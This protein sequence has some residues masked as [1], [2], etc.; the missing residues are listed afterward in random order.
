MTARVLLVDDEADLLESLRL[1]LLQEGPFEVH[2]ESD[3]RVAL[4]RVGE[5]P[6]DL[7]V[8]DL[9][10][11]G[12]HGLEVL[13]ELSRSQPLAECIVLTAVQDP[14]MAVQALKMGAF[15]YL[16]KPVDKKKLLGLV[17]RVLHLDS[18]GG[19]CDAREAFRKRLEHPE[20]FA[21]IVTVSPKMAQIFR[22]LER[23]APTEESVVISGPSGTGKELIAR[24]IH[25]L[26]PR[27]N[28]PFVGV[29][30]AAIPPSLFAS[31][32][33]GHAAGAFSGAQGRR[34]G[35]AEEAAEGTLFL[36][37]IGELDQGLQVQLL[38][39]LQEREYFVVGETTPTPLRARVV[40]ASNR[41]LEEETG[42]GRFR[43]DLFYRLNATS[44]HVPPLAKRPEDIPHLVNHFA[45]TLSARYGKPI[46]SVD[47]RLV[48]LLCQYPFPG[49]VRELQNVIREA[50]LAEDT[51]VLR[52]SSLPE[53]Y[54][55]KIGRDRSLTHGRGE[56]VTLAELER[57]HIQRVLQST[58][59]NV[60]QAAK[61]LGI[62]R[63]TLGRRLR[64][65][66]RA[67]S[68]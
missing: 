51:G 54:R 48:K 7:V 16:T 13:D 15:D 31:E 47:P 18:G 38:R 68:P 43:A 36:D 23:V 67:A 10:M 12:V 20:A 33:F 40:V 55:H 11:P 25:R 46:R 59:G 9:N 56:L 1:L 37:E 32:L 26:S 17:R 58:G 44:V 39:V 28:G 62:S 3:S 60:T 52:P 42:S 65:W 35:F 57:E 49:N 14:A 53:A 8:L 19:A 6:W 4:R 29:N 22:Y 61:V 66:R 41:D 63:A 27:R 64:E 50:V 34:R 5:E 30:I 21:D 24:A 45:R 2:A